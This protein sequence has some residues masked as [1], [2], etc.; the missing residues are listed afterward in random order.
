[1]ADPVRLP[2]SDPERPLREA[3]AYLHDEL[4]P[5]EKAA[6]EAHLPTCADCQESIRVG[7]FVFPRVYELLAADRRPR[8]DADL[9][10]LLDQAQGEVDAEKHTEAPRP[11]PAP[12]PTRRPWTFV[13]PW[14]VGGLALAAALLV[15]LSRP[16]TPEPKLLAEKAHMEPPPERRDSAPAPPDT[17]PPF[18]AELRGGKIHVHVPREPDDRYVGLALVDAESGVWLLRRSDS[19]ELCL[20]GCDALDVDLDVTR[21]PPGTILVYVL[22]A[23]RPIPEAELERWVTTLQMHEPRP[24]PRV[25]GVRVVER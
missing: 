13:I 21:L 4:T 20:F 17:E 25:E 19:R 15:L 3:A 16:G 22:V 7:R 11:Q 5:E 14:L 23:P 6:F 12:V 8:S 10:A 9:L 1:M 24:W 2:H 18:D